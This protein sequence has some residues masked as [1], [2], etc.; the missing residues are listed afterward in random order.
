MNDVDKK[1][2]SDVLFS[3][4]VNEVGFETQI[5]LMIKLDPKRTI[6]ILEDLTLD[7]SFNV[8]LRALN[9][10][11]T[12]AENNPELKERVCV[13][14]EKVYQMA[15]DQTAE[16]EAGLIRLNFK[17]YGGGVRELCGISI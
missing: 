7:S 17:G 2:L 11:R 6:D 1:R 5:G 10:L 4:I 12:I 13:V 9:F 3:K 16:D 15:K 14:G 8:R